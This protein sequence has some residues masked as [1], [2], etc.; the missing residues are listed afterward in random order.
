M[1]TT[2]GQA[3]LD[4]D[5]SDDS[6]DLDYFDDLDG[7]GPLSDV[8]DLITSQGGRARDR[9]WETVTTTGDLL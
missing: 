5:D 6:D 1:A 9:R 2:P 4:S 8:L 7:P 3:P